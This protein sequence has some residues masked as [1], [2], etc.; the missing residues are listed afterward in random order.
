MFNNSFNGY[1]SRYFLIVVGL[2]LTLSVEASHF[3]FGHFTWEARPDISPTTVDFRMMVA[4]RSSAFGHPNI[5]QTFRPGRFYFGDG[6][7]GYYNF[8]VIARNLQEDW[9]VGRAIQ[10][11]QE[12]GVVRYNYRDVNN[13]GVPWKAN[14]SSCCKIGSLRNAANASWRVITLVNLENGNSS[15]F[16]NLPPIVTCSKF[17]CRFRVPAVDPNGDRLT[18]RM[19]TR[20]E[21]A[22]YSIPSGMSVDRDTGVLTWSGS[23][24]FTNGLYSVQVVIEDRDEADN[25]KSNTAIDF[26]INLQ[27]QGA[28]AWPEFDIPPTPENGSVIKAVVGQPLNLTIQATDSDPNDIVYLNHVGLPLGATFE[29]TTS[30]GVIGVANLQWIPTTD[31]MGQH[32]VTFLA[33]DNRGGASTPVAVTIDVIKPAISD[34][35]IVSTISTTDITIDANTYSITPSH[36]AIEGERTV[37]TWE[38]PTFNVG[39]IENLNT[40]LRLSNLQPNEQRIITEKLEVFYTDIDGQP[41]YEILDEQKVKVAP[42]LTRISVDTDKEIYLP[43]ETVTI[44]SLLENLSDVA[45]DATVVIDVVDSQQTL[46]ANIGTFTESG[47][48]ALAQ[49]PLQDNL[50]SVVGV[51]AGAYEVV[52]KIVENGDVVLQATAPFAITTESGNFINVSALV[53]TDKPKYQAWD[54][55]IINLRALNLSNNATFNGG[56]GELK[57]LLPNGEV[58]AKQVYSLNSL[59]PQA[60]TDRQFVLPLV[61][62]EAGS[63]QVTWV[64]TQNGTELATSSTSFTV[65]RNE[66]ASLLGAVK[67]NYYPTVEAQSCSFETTNR[68]AITPVTATLIYQLVNL[69]TS[70][71]VYEIKE[72]N[73]AISNTVAHPYQLLLSDPPAY[74]GYGCI[75]MADINGELSQLAASGFE[76]QPPKINAS[77]ELASKGKLLVLVDDEKYILSSDTKL[78]LEQRQYLEQLLSSNQW[79]YTLVDNKTDFSKEFYS[80]IYSAIAIFSEKVSLKDDVEDLLVEAQ[81]RGVGL[82]ISGNWNRRN[83][84]LE[85]ALG[86]KVEGLNK[87]T[88]AIKLEDG[89]IDNPVSVDA[90]VPQGLHLENCNAEIWARFAYGK[91]HDD[92]HDDDKHDDDHCANDD[93]P[94]AVTAA[95]YGNG[96]NNYF[97]YDVLDLAAA[98]QGLHEQLLLQ[99]LTHIQPTVWPVG[100]GEVIPVKFDIENLSRKAAV[101]IIFSLPQGGAIIESQLPLQAINGKWLWQRDFSTP[102]SASNVLYIQLPTDVEG[103]IYLNADINA[104]INRQLI[105]DNQELL[106]KLGTIPAGS[107]YQRALILAEKLKL[108]DNDDDLDDIIKEL[109]KTQSKVDKKQYNN[110]IHHLLEAAE[111]LS[112]STLPLAIETRLVIDEW[113][114]QLQQLVKEFVSYDDDDDHEKEKKDD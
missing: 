19:A 15:P 98:S 36:I 70:E 105:V 96:K 24:S 77:I 83:S 67:V 3:R 103:D 111:E 57:V 64:I 48:A 71:L 8:E 107:P 58:L 80:G 104:G 76:A 114:Y 79:N 81:N 97:A 16:S 27:D 39:Q 54:Q 73:T 66:L 78:P 59:A 85:K 92:K 82:L 20:S 5:G 7:S 90:L 68:S 30:G 45:V 21:S 28:N 18:W 53:N 109:N 88:V 65:E 87:S 46:V 2:L 95:K 13:N 38:F 102:A 60:I 84:D 50:F 11:G 41:V 42:T 23:E 12:P 44:S 61:D 63:Y 108:V 17:D 4:F 56:Q 62:R 51:Y 89:A 74:G 113:L 72:P 110:A 100:A 9:I 40:T 1:F 33:N 34:V 6:G 91:H 52:A 31:D 35:R 93:V 47:I 32:L 75:L 86:I 14:F 55:A 29:Q 49:R 101:D 22:I 25:I 99:A 26:I 37:V 43:T 94:L 112:E 106:F 10:S 69:D